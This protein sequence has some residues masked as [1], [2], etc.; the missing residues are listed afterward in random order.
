MAAGSGG[1]TTS[2]ARPDAPACKKKNPKIQNVC[3][4]VR[5]RGRERGGGEGGERDGERGMLCVR[6]ACVCARVPVGNDFQA[7]LASSSFTFAA[8]VHIQNVKASQDT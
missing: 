1:A 3:V 6:V 7:H 8:C 5:E 4:C 2:S